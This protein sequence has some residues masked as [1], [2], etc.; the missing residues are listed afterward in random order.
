MKKLD[1]K[2]LN[3]TLN[4]WNSH[5]LTSMSFDRLESFGFCYSMMPVINKLY[6][7]DIEAKKQAMKRHMAF[8]NT[9]PQ[10][11]SLI[12]GISCGMEEQRA[13]G[14]D[15]N[16]T[17]INS[18]KLGLMGPI[19]GI[20]DSMIPGTFI[21][22]LLSVALML[23][24][25][26]SPVGAI[27]YILAYLGTMI[28]LTK[29]LFKEGYTLGLDAIKIFTSENAIKVREGITRLGILI[30]GGIAASYVNLST[31]L[32]FNYDSV[33]IEIQSMI[34]GIF[35]K[36]LPLT[37]VLLTYFFMRKGVNPIKM[38]LV[39]IAFATVGVLLGIF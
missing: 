20:G 30:M 2:V 12:I 34:D 21:P 23:S 14:H 32:K 16:D 13:N 31:P 37:L 7:D 5:N 39:F 26:G 3:Q 15:I 35:P 1:N 33:N 8:Y 4:R 36:I 38:M 25:N 28:F 6:G 22:I 29:F 9:E 24:T 17:T 18:I 19:A 27:F 10:L 11:G